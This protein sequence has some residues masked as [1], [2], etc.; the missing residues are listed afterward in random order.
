MTGGASLRAATPGGGGGAVAK[1]KTCQLKL[2]HNNNN[3]LQDKLTILASLENW[4][5][6]SPGL[7]VTARVKPSL[8]GGLGLRRK[9]TNARRSAVLGRLNSHGL[10]HDGAAMRIQLQLGHGAAQ[11]RGLG[12]SHRRH[13]TQGRGRCRLQERAHG[14]GLTQDAIHG[15]E[16]V[17][18]DQRFAGLQD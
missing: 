6:H 9:G 17:G 11:W 16:V 12:A 4:A 3:K 8:A 1:R 14:L 15:E 2:I 7:L 13:G 18:V 10:A 5:L